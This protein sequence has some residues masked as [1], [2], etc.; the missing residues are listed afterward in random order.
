MKFPS[1]YIF[2]LLLSYCY[3]FGF[4]VKND[5]KI[6]ESTANRMIIEFTPVYKDNIRSRKTPDGSYDLVDFYNSMSQSSS[7][8]KNSYGQPDLPF[9]S[10]L[11]GLP[12]LSG[13]NVEIISS[14]FESVPN[15]NLPPLPRFKKGE[16]TLFPS[17]VYE[18]DL[19]IYNQNNF[20][21]AITAFL[22][23]PGISRDYILSSLIIYP[24]QYNPVTKELRKYKKLVI[25]ITFGSQNPA[26]IQRSINS[27]PIK[28]DMVGGNVINY[29]QMKNWPVTVNNSNRVTLAKSSVLSSGDWYK[30]EVNDEGIYKLD[31]DFFKKAGISTSSIDPKT[32]KIYGNG[33]EEVSE[34]LNKS[35]KDDLVECAIYV[36]GESDGKFDDASDYVLFYGKGALGWNYDSQSKKFTHYIHHY[37]NSNYYFLTFG[38]SVKGKRMS[39]LASLNSSSAV[40]AKKV[41]AKYFYEKEVNNGINSGRQWFGIKL[42]NSFWSTTISSP[43]L[44]GI[45]GDSIINYRVQC[46]AS[47]GLP[48]SF[49]FYQNDQAL[50]LIYIYYPAFESDDGNY[51]Q[52]SEVTE[53]AKKTDIKDNI[54]KFKFTYTPNSSGDAGYIDWIEAFYPRSLSTASTVDEIAFTSPAQNNVVDLNLNGF[55]SRNIFAFNLKDHNDVKIISNPTI[56]GGNIRFQIQASKES[57]D[58]YCVVG[59]N[60]FKSIS[61]IK[62]LDNSNLHGLSDGADFL[63]ISHPDFITEAERYRAYREN[64]TINKLKTKVIDVTTI[65][66]EFSGGLMDPTA[67]RDFVKYFYENSPSNLRPKYL[68]LFGDASYDYKGILKS[69]GSIDRNKIPPYETLESLDRV[70]S[71]CSDDYYARIIGSD[72]RDDLGIGRLNIVSIAEAKSAVDKIIAYESKN[73]FG[74]WRNTITFVAD[75]G[76]TS[77]GDDGNDYTQQSE[78]LAEY[79]APIEFE[80][81]KIFIV[82]YP[83]IIGSSG[84]LKPEANKAIIDQINLGSLIVNYIGHGNPELWAHEHIFMTNES[85]QLL[86]NSDKLPFLIAATCDFGRYDDPQKQSGTEVI[87]NKANGGMIG[88][89][90]ASRSVYAG[91]NFS[92]ARAF[93]Q[94]LFSK[95]TTQLLPRLGDVMFAIKQDFIYTNDNKFHLFGDPSVRVCAPQYTAAVDSIN[96]IS[97]AAPIQ[98]KALSKVSIKGKVTKDSYVLWKDFNGKV[99]ITITDASKTMEIKEG[100]GDFIWKQDGGILYRGECSA[101]NGEFYS[102]F[103]IPK[104]ISYENNNGRITLYFQDGNNDGA[105]VS[106]NII[107]GGSDT[108]NVSDKNG[109][110]INVFLGDRNFHDGDPTSENPK[111]IV[112]LFDESGINISGGIGHRFEAQLDNSINSIGLIDYYKGKVD[113]Y[114]EGTAEYN[115]A[116]LENGNHRLKVKAFDVF[117]NT[118]TKEISFKVSGSS[119]LTILN[120][121]NYPNPFSKSTKFTFQQNMEEPIDVKIKIF[122]IAGRL[123]K[124]ID[125]R[126]INNHFVQID[127]DGKDD[128]GDDIANGIYLYKLTTTTQDGRLTNDALGRLSVIK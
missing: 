39:S 7:Y 125:E 101:K 106:K 14:E 95:E 118:T 116:D 79:V 15:M 93:Y 75:D 6:I 85:P 81:K 127:W 80:K 114:Q 47:S 97:A 103:Y 33:G 55:S 56:S 110:V 120:V 45:M 58:P 119:G 8:G 25:R 64:N 4:Q 22:N 48:S 84:K 111:L 89:F 104:D 42:S 72:D 52:L 121:L 61:T 65:Y 60:G 11:I 29:E 53:F 108:I 31:A 88:T 19:K 124:T 24:V 91:W 126:G 102:T 23:K 113:S 54:L 63:I 5:I 40:Q 62:K 128:D 28:E 32:I 115:L 49:N 36:V 57:I 44:D 68:L 117:N 70:E 76:Y 30:L 73:N 34:D 20:Y 66:N 105:G 10:I 9:R 92:I 86:T 26:K 43:K 2:F 71:Y 38:G 12:A 37:S 50:G 87:I 109:P 1:K 17:P 13:N 94:K 3:M 59:N 67:I 96:G 83:T 46:A 107:I 112:D 98:L 90:S 69:S 51:A 122:T 18:K 123:I 82:A 35:R 27:I 74:T 16:D 21:P 99:G 41:D 77:N 100:I 78:E